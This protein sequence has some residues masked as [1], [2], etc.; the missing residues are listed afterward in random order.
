MARRAKTRQA[1]I[2]TT[3]LK[4]IFFGYAEDT[5]GETIKL[6]DARMCLYWSADL[7]GFMGLASFGPNE[8]CRIGPRASSIT[9]REISCVIAGLSDEAIANWEA[10]PWKC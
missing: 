3:K 9:L 1:V 4:G 8:N 5:D 7:R 2:V 10:A 6:Y